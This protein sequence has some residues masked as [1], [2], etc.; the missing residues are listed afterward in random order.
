MTFKLNYRT[1]KVD[2]FVSLY[3]PGE[4]AL[5]LLMYGVRQG[6]EA[7]VDSCVRILMQ[8][9]DVRRP[10]EDVPP[11]H[12]ALLATSKLFHL[13]AQGN[14]TLDPDTRVFLYYHGAQVTEKIRRIAAESPEPQGSLVDNGQCCSIATRLE[15]LTAMQP[16]LKQE[17]YPDLDAVNR[18]IEDGVSYLIDSQYRKGDSKGGVPWVSRHHPASKTREISPEIRIDTV[19]HSISAIL[20]AQANLPTR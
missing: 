11:D 2:D 14:V 19:Q 15:G 8:L 3:Y 12:W 17:E 18:L 13:A 16:W 5:G 1:G 20:G 10:Q 7:A 9:A 6:D 4:V